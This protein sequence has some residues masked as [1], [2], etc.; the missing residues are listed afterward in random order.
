ME[1]ATKNPLEVGN[2]TNTISMKA[3]KNYIFPVKNATDI[4]NI[5]LR[6]NFGSNFSH[7]LNIGKAFH[8]PT[9]S[10]IEQYG[11]ENLFVCIQREPSEAYVDIPMAGRVPFR[12]RYDVTESVMIPYI[13]FEKMKGEIPTF[14]RGPKPTNWN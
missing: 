1:I 9:K 4:Y 2:P 12:V 7:N 14:N 5:H 11:K 6:K 10:A 3:K 8:I 13:E